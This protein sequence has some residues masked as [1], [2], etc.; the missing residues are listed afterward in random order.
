MSSDNHY[1]HPRGLDAHLRQHIEPIVFTEAQIQEAQI[2]YLALQQRVCL[3]RAI[4]S[5]DAVAF[6]FQA[7]AKGS[8]DGGFVVH[9]Q[10]AA[11]LLSG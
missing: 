6:V 10:N 5:G 3:G 7:I 2:E 1:P 4:R 11:L 9:Q 8:Q